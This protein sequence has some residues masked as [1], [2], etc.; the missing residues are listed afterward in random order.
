MAQKGRTGSS[1]L[2]L[3]RR[4]AGRGQAGKGLDWGGPHLTTGWAL[5]NDSK[6]KPIGV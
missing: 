1:P 5:V 2:T 4:G 3:L 6:G